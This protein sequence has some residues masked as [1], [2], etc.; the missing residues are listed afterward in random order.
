MRNSCNVCFSIVRQTKETEYQNG[1]ANEELSKTT[2]QN[3]TKKIT[4]E[5]LQGE[6]SKEKDRNIVLFATIYNTFASITNT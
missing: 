1:S 2:Q 4:S 6:S 3:C 5:I